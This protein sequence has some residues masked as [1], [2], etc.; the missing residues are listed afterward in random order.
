MRFG[1][2]M[3]LAP[4]LTLVFLQA[5]RWAAG[6]RAGPRDRLPPAAAVLSAPLPAAEHRGEQEAEQGSQPRQ[7]PPERYQP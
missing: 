6:R 2:S 4:L 7:R 1:L 3:P 5:D